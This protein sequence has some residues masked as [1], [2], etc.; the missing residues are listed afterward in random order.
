LQAP[1]FPPFTAPDRVAPRPDTLLFVVHIFF[2]LVSCFFLR[3][4][5][6]P[7]CFFEVFP[8]YYKSPKRG[9]KPVAFPFFTIRPGIFF[10]SLV[11][12]PLCFSTRRV[13]LPFPERKYSEDPSGVWFC[14][15]WS[16][17]RSPLV[18]PLFWIRSLACG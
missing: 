13:P 8:S 15:H 3:L 14:P 5:V 18:T 2:V 16:Q 1:Q 17:R 4:P 6:L 12:S 7:R 11:P 10:T 9:S